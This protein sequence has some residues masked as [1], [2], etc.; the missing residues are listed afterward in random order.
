MADVWMWR[1]VKKRVRDIL[2][3]LTPVEGTKCK[4]ADF[5]PSMIS[6]KDGYVI[7]VRS[8]RNAA[9]P[10]VA[11]GAQ[12]NAPTF[13]IKVYSPQVKTGLETVQEDRIEAY[14]D[15]IRNLFDRYPM[16]NN[17]DPD[18]TIK[19]QGLAGLSNKITL[20]GEVFQSPDPYAQ[21]GPINHYTVTF[22]LT[23]PF[24]RITG[25]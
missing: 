4:V 25:C 11:T 5:I 6:D 12:P 10:S 21:G 18:A 20:G 9:T 14:A 23:V 2:K 17:P 15:A 7:I 1:D 24:E 22:T 19:R 16:L 3:T 13:T 8:T